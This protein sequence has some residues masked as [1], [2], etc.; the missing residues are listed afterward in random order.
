M[1]LPTHQ[2]P[3]AGGWLKMPALPTGKVTKLQGSLF[4]S[5]NTNYTKPEADI[6]QEV[7]VRHAKDNEGFVNLRRAVKDIEPDLQMPGTYH[8]KGEVTGE[9]AT[10][11]SSADA[12]SNGLFRAADEERWEVTSWIPVTFARPCTVYRTGYVNEAGA[13]VLNALLGFDVVPL[14]RATKIKGR[15]GALMVHEP[16]F[17]PAFQFFQDHP[18][19][20]K[21]GEG[22]EGQFRWT[23]KSRQQFTLEVQKLAIVDWMCRNLNRT[24]G[25]WYVRVVDTEEVEIRGSG[26]DT[27]FAQTF[28]YKH[29]WVMRWG[30]PD[31]VLQAEWAEELKQQVVPL[32]T[33]REW[34]GIASDA[35][36]HTQFDHHNDFEEGFWNSQWAIFRGQAYLLLNDLTRENGSPLRLSKGHP[37]LMIAH[38]G[39]MQK[40]QAGVELYIEPKELGSSK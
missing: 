37:K 21:D 26:P 20:A 2:K 7:G 36:Y 15:L 19:E 5:K 17:V 9:P 34:W 18:W 4:F 35:L 30:L 38:H 1:S 10:A 11:G 27:G 28:P 16:D 29:P 8:T 3:A 22:A 40:V 31:K 14:T 12:G 23:E 39:G 33:S 25:N 13:S 6:I 32:L 24:P